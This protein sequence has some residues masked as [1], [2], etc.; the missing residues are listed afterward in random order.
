MMSFSTQF[1]YV[2]EIVVLEGPLLGLFCRFSTFFQSTSNR[3]L[4]KAL[5]HMYLFSFRWFLDFF[6][7]LPLSW[8]NG[9]RFTQSNSSYLPLDISIDFLTIKWIFRASILLLNFSFHLGNNSWPWVIRWK[10]QQV[11]KIHRHQ[12]PTH[13][14]HPHQSYLLP[15]RGKAV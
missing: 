9:S 13:H 6:I 3:K 15:F 1:E 2:T 14:F 12:I 8:K 10:E 5:L 7:V 4:G 11:L